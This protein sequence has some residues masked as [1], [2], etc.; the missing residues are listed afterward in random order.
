VHVANAV[1]DALP[2]AAGERGAGALPAGRMTRR[3]DWPQ[4][5]GGFAWTQEYWG[6]ALHCRPALPFAPHLFTTGDLRLVDD[7]NEWAAVAGR[8]GVAPNRLRLIA[9]VHGADVAVVRPGTRW[10]ADRPVA[11]IVI[12]DDPDAAIGVRVADCAPILLADVRLGTVG[13]VHAGWRGTARRA[14]G[15]AVAA[16][17]RTFGSAPRDLIAAIG[18]CLGACCGEVGPEVVAV[19]RDAGHDRGDLERWFADGPSGRPFL[20]LWEANRDQ[21]LRA[22]VPA[23]RVFIAGL[24]TKTHSGLLHSY[25]AHGAAAGRMAGIIRAVTP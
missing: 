17:A 15:V 19:F 14:A 21:L 4:P 9:Q 10:G 16:M 25:R 22:G 20:D 7:L 24:C 3:A 12:S 23:D 11:D 18:P 6:T 1:S 13:A 2:M 8:L 5:T